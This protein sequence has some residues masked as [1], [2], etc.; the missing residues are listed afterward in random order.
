MKH[1]MI[2]LLAAAACLSLPGATT[3]L[4]AGDLQAGLAVVD[5]T[6]PVPYRMC[7]YFNERLSTGIHD[8]L[9]AKALVLREGD[10]QLAMVFCDLV[11]IST[12]ISL[13]AR[14]AAEKKTGI[15]KDNILIACT[16]T[17]TGPLFRCALRDYFHEQAIA[18]HGSDPYEKIDYPAVIADRV[19]EAVTRAYAALRPAA[20][21]A[22]VAKETGLSFNRRFHMKDGSVVFNPGKLNPNIVRP[23]G[24]IDPDVDV[25][26]V[27]DA[28]GSRPLAS[29]TV[30]ALHLDTMGGTLYSADYPYWME[31]SLREEFGKGFISLFGNGTCGD[32]NHI[33]FTSAHAQPGGVETERIGQALAAKVK[34]EI[35]KLKTLP[36][37]RLAVRT[38]TVLAPLQKYT[39]EEI[40][41]AKGSMDKIGTDK[42]SF[43]DQVKAYK[44]MDL[45]SRK[46]D[47]LPIFVQ[48][49]R[50]G[51]EVALVAL[52]GEVFVE[53]GLAIK[54]AS[55]FPLTMVVELAHDTP[56]Y[57]PTRKAF[58]EGSYETVNSRIQPGGG[59]MAVEAAIRLL[60]Q[61]RDDKP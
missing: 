10:R 14:E 59:E 29:L 12:E 3:A 17:H 46:G 30:F 1:G 38:E 18:K 47:L 24:P 49:F 7:G 41:W 45:Q 21:A 60:R 35:P 34:A 15:P 56:D 33:N 54:R 42:L 11:G 8:P 50:I 39:P 44:I 2:A 36:Q 52:P 4:G 20:L 5:I 26:L 48:T 6:P 40:A 16:H 55:P 58:A 13:R 37:P 19:A 25:V 23:A 53:L 22:A 43:L 51:D 57:V 28:A 31:Q 32:I 61:L 9:N 27:R